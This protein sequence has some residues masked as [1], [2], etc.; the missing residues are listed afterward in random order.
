MLFFKYIH[1]EA[2]SKRKDLG[3]IPCDFKNVLDVVFVDF[4]LRVGSWWDMGRY[5]CIF[6]IHWCSLLVLAFWLVEW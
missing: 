5:Q 6:S 1:V 2:K 4:S 3:L